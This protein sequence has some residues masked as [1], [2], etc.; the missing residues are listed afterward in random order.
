MSTLLAEIAAAPWRETFPASGRAVHTPEHL[1]NLLGDDPELHR[2]A[3]SYLNGNVLHQ[4]SAFPSAAITA[5]FVA[6]M[7]AE[8]LVSNRRLQMS[9]LG[10]LRYAAGTAVEINH[11]V[12]ELRSPEQ[13]VD[14]ERLGS[15]RRW[16]S[17]TAY[18]DPPPEVYGYDFDAFSELLR[19]GQLD[20]YETMPTLLGVLLPLAEQRSQED[21]AAAT[22]SVGALAQV[23]GCDEALVAYREAAGRL[24]SSSD[25]GIRA[26]AVLSLG[27]LGGDPRRH[28]SDPWIVV[29][30][31][32]AV[33]PGLADETT[34]HEVLAEL[35]AVPQ[36]FDAAVA[37][38][39]SLARPLSHHDV[40]RAACER[41]SDVDRLL[42]GVAAMTSDSVRIGGAVYCYLQCFFAAGWPS[43][44]DRTAGQRRLARF[45]AGSDRFW[46]PGMEHH[47]SGLLKKLGLPDDRKAWRHLAEASR[48]PGEYSAEDLVVFE[49]GA[50][51]RNRLRMYL[52]PTEHG[53]AR[54]IVEQLTQAY[55]VAV[56]EHVVG[57][58]DVTLDGETRFVL[59]AWDHTLPA[60]HLNRILAGALITA[61]PPL[62][63]LSM[64]AAMC[65]EAI[66]TTYTGGRA[67][68]QRFVAGTALGPAL[69]VKAEAQVDGYRIEFTFDPSATLP[70]D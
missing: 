68:V 22:L 70:N 69:P 66:V 33:A 51:I 6:R 25:V 67:F 27:R 18:D 36:A 61:Q 10:F 3:L 50:A 47:R 54:A 43:V 38:W 29:R 34:A 53:L 21:I 35:I 58:A 42:P 24:A 45:V 9:L 55:E 56:S 1:R 52:G 14:A 31:F 4:D 30:G 17:D 8:G 63:Q 11:F 12:D 15:Y 64:T 39:P 46:Y 49:A 44:V 40:V 60:E 41:I 13:H 59:T 37:D 2:Q 5:V 48:N 20:L 32:A 28:L 57:Q 7:L 19:L 16:L 65:S 23:P 26:S 62:N